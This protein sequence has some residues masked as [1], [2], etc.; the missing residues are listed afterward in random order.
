MLHHAIRSAAPSAPM[1]EGFG[2]PSQ[3]SDAEAALLTIAD[4]SPDSRISLIGQNT[5]EL[6]CALLRRGSIDVSAMRVSDRPPAAT[7]DLAVIAH[8]ASPDCLERTIAHARRILAP[9]GTIAIHLA[10][11]PADP[12]SQQ[13]GRSLLLHGFSSIRTFEYAGE[14]LVRA[15]LPLYGRLACA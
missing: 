13:A 8:V 5:L 2:H 3:L 14:T 1:S 11:H 10:A 15:E 6:L 4:P 9:L 7:A 12:L